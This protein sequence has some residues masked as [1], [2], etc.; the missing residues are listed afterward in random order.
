MS[1]SDYYIVDS[2]LEKIYISE[3]KKLQKKLKI[4]YKMSALAI[5]Y[6]HFLFNYLLILALPCYFYCLIRKFTHESNISPL[7]ILWNYLKET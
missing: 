7:H 4:C 6:F 2:I 5:I 3:R 1:N